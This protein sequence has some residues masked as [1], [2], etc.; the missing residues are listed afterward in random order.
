M[1]T[2]DVTPPTEGAKIEGDGR[3]EVSAATVAR[4]LGV[5]TTSDLRVL[6]AKLD[7]FG[8]K[9]AT[10]AAKLDKVSGA[11][12]KIPSA[13][14]LERIDV[15]IGSLRTQV[16]EAVDVLKGLAPATAPKVEAAPAT[17]KDVLSAVNKAKEK[18]QANASVTP[19]S[20]TEG[21]KS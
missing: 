5:A 21:D 7:L 15:Q 1:T 3:G 11:L 10:F 14:D 9:I 6:E 12:A 17:V 13:G 4:L 16:R 19:D 8:T 20:A 2:D 18:A